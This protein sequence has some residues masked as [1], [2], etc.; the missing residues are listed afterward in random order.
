[1]MQDG[2][3]I[4]RNKMFILRNYSVIYRLHNSLPGTEQ[5]RIQANNQMEE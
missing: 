4:V 1:M 2:A 3:C 5:H